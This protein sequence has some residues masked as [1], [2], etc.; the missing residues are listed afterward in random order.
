MTVMTKEQIEA[1]LDGTT[2]GPWEAC[3]EVWSRKIYADGENRVCFMAHSNG[4]N[5]ERD[6]STSELVA[7]A[8]DLARTA[9]ALH[10]QLADAHAAQALVVERAA[11]MIEDNVRHAKE[12]GREIWAM[13]D[14]RALADPS[15]VEALAA[16]RD[17]AEKWRSIASDNGRAAMDN[18]AAIV[19]LEGERDALAAKL[20][21]AEARVRALQAKVDASEHELREMGGLE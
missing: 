12:L 20:A 21:A 17:E 2:P 5:D 3:G 6:I 15:G 14:L 11:D 16:L 1:L 7:A 9:L 4:L 19:A 8:P 18:L 10:Q 13:P